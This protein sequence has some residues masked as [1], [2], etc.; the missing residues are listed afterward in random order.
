MRPDNLVGKIGRVS[1]R[2]APDTVGEVLLPVRGGEEAFLAH[3]YDGEEIILPNVRVLVIN[4]VGRAV[5][6]T[7]RTEAAH[8]V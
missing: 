8:L 4:Q 1:G 6:V 5:Y 3:A 7:A 2:I